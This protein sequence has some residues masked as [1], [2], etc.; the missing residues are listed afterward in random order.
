MFTIDE[1]IIAVYCCVDDCLKT[2]TNSQSP[3][4]RG[5]EPGLSDAEVLTMEIVAEYQGI[6]RDKAIWQ[7]FRRHWRAWFLQLPSRSSFSRHSA[8]LWH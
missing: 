4:R 8:N 1:F 6:D 7:Y 5:F 2:L 3:R